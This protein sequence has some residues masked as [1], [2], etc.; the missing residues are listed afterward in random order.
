MWWG[1][2][3]FCI[4]ADPVFILSV[5]LLSHIL[6]ESFLYFILFFIEVQLIYN[7]VLIPGV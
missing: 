6:G 7:I 3:G 1:E 4:W 5:P 2:G